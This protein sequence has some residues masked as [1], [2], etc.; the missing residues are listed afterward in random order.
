MRVNTTE[1]DLSQQAAPW[2]GEELVHPLPV[3][4][5]VVLGLNDHWLKGSGWLP[6]W[7]TGKVSDFA[8]L[9]FFPFFLTA[10][11]STFMYGLFR[12]SSHV[13]LN[14]SLTR[15]KLWAAILITGAIF[16]PLQFSQEWVELYIAG[17]EMLDVLDWFGGFAVTR[18]PTD[19]VA[20]GMFPVV[21][22]QGRQ[23]L[24]RF[25]VGRLAVIR[26]RVAGLSP[27]QGQKV[28]RRA[29]RDLRALADPRRRGELD[30][31]TQL[32]CRYVCAGDQAALKPAKNALNNF[33][34]GG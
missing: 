19:L 11:I 12:L 27:A 10:L 7:V 29:T 21:Y 14:Y 22:W 6:A 24:L 20:L 26:R 33:R 31:F 13:R 3:G 34:R 18:D 25:P 23:H 1:I 4:A 17:L 8:G 2:P 5:M 32:Y 16:V 30:R 9:L 15:W 28:F